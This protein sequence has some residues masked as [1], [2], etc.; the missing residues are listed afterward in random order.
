MNN[1]DKK[2]NKQ[3]RIYIAVAIGFV[4]LALTLLAC[5][6]LPANKSKYAEDKQEKVNITRSSIN[7]ICELTTLKCYYHNVAA[8]EK[9]PDGLLKY[10]WGQLGYR[11]FWTEYEGIIEI[12]V[13]VRLVD[14]VYDRDNNTLKIYIPDAKIIACNC[15]PESIKV[16]A[17]ETGFF[18]SI[19]AEDRVYAHSEAQKA[20]R[21]NAEQDTALM[22]RA[23][24]NAKETI[25]SIYKLIKKDINIVWLS[26]PM[27]RK[28]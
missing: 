28:E 25:E 11:K 23:K 26:E 9:Q 16:S 10:G 12:G 5:V 19:V 7:K 24:E 14:F 2:I 22:A 1:T 3:M 17:S 20:M 8:F 27:K 15:D 6:V 4:V 18:T 13:D 21:Q